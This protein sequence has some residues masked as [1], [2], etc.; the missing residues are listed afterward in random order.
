MKFLRELESKFQL[1]HS[2]LD[3]INRKICIDLLLSFR[4]IKKLGDE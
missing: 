2:L 4:E 1:F 3:C